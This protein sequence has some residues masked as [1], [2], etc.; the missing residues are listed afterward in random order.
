MAPLKECN[1][2]CAFYQNRVSRYGRY[3]LC[4]AAPWWP[5]LSERRWTPCLTRRNSWNISLPAA[6]PSHI[7]FPVR[8]RPAGRGIL[9]TGCCWQMKD[10][11]VWGALWNTGSEGWSRGCSAR[12]SDTIGRRSVPDPQRA[13]TQLHDAFRTH[14]RVNCLYFYM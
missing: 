10:R 4:V 11:D 6:E 2:T 9:I 1:R 7:C 14:L 5:P 13:S 12:W 8:R 3:C